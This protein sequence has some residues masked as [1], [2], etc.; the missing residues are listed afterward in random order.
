ML[1]TSE[2]RT[3]PK[4]LERRLEE[5][6]N[7]SILSRPQHCWALDIWGDLQLPRLKWK[8]IRQGW[9]EILAWSILLYTTKNNNI[10][11]DIV[12][13]WIVSVIWQKRESDAI[14]FLLLMLLVVQQTSVSNYE[15]W[16]VAA[17]CSRKSSGIPW[18]KEWTLLV[19]T[20]VGR[21]LS[22]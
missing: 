10:D 12:L 11:L 1:P 7:E 16:H 18:Q 21:W 8:T 13:I 14:L 2:L 17:T 22:R 4:G 15:F 9:C 5:M 20:S 6:E 19:Q 3:I